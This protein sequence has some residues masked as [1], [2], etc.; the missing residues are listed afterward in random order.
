MI[1]PMSAFP[2]FREALTQ[3]LEE[4]REAGID[5][6]QLASELRGYAQSC[7]DQYRAEYAQSK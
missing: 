7:D 2:D 3:L 6:D 4:A 1:R 5:N